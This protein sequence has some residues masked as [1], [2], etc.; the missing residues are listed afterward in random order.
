LSH[1]GRRKPERPRGWRISCAAS[2]L[3]P[4]PSPASSSSGSPAARLIR[5]SSFFM[6]CLKTQPLSPLTR[7]AITLRPSSQGRLCRCSP[8]A[9][10][11]SICSFDLSDAISVAGESSTE[12]VALRSTLSAPF[13]A[14]ES[15][16][17]KLDWPAS[18]R[19]WRF[20]YV[21]GCPYM[22]VGVPKCA[23]HLVGKFL[24]FF[25]Q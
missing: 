16:K 1:S 6:S 24:S 20:L 10:G 19:R 3:A 17:A 5:P 14:G 21:S 15:K 25:G 22:S 12:P 4:K 7:A 9:S 23:H 13:L 18:S 2:C 8:D 11:R